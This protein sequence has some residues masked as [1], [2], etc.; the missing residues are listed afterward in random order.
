M[1][2]SVLAEAGAALGREDWLAA[3]VQAA[4]FLL[5]RLRRHGGGEDGADREAGGRWLRAWHQEGGARHLAYAADHAWLVDAFTR[6]AEATG[7]A[8]WIDH[9]RAAADALLA[10]FRD[11]EGGG[12][13]TTGSDA[14][15]LIVRS[16][17]V[18]DG[19]TP[20]ANAVAAVALARLGALV[21]DEGYAD[22]SREIVRLV[23]P[24]AAE[25]PTAFTHALAAAD[26]AVSG[27]TEVAVVG[28]RPDLVQAVQ[29]HYLP[30]AV[31]AWGEPYPS[32]LWEGRKEGW[33]YVCR[34]YACRAPV[35]TAAALLAEAST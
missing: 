34:D 2:I 8:R 21:G 33:A 12:V 20:S 28:Q 29:E 11:R 35:D 7:Q 32:P 19:A 1:M 16:K 3:A 9:A 22:A 18:F 5:A 23:A 15:Q 4:Q 26:M 24:T 25:H 13:F 17:D 31:L 30:N 27:I 14:E 6:L 10:L